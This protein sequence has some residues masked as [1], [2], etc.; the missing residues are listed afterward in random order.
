VNTV[1]LDLIAEPGAEVPPA[2]ARLLDGLPRA[3]D[4]SPTA[5]HLVVHG[6]MAHPE[7]VRAAP[8][9]SP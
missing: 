7:V 8:D 1:D 9:G 3:A 4:V 2:I 5:R 6:T